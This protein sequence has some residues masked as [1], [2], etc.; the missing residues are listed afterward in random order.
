M[1]VKRFQEIILSRQSIMK[2]V[3]LK[4][5]SNSQIMFNLKDYNLLTYS[6]HK[7]LLN[8]LLLITNERIR[9]EELK[10]KRLNYSK[11]KKQL[12]SRKRNF[13][14][15]MDK[16]QGISKVCRHIRMWSQCQLSDPDMMKLS[17]MKLR[18]TIF[19][20]KMS[21]QLNELKSHPRDCNRL[22][23]VN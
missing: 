12:N 19:R 1:L 16:N 15:F 23:V 18:R 22:R 20:K 8:D 14:R 10:W 9:R 21:Y 4:V 11:I 13:I 3:L 7:G 17:L 5:L 6:N 2:K